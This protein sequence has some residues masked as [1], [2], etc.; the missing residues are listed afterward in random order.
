M[1]VD[2]YGNAMAITKTD[3]MILKVYATIY[4]SFTI[5][6][7]YY[8]NAGIAFPYVFGNILGTTN[9][10]LGVAA[11]QLGPINYANY[12]LLDQSATIANI[13][14]GRKISFDVAGA[15]M[16]NK[17]VRHIGYGRQYVWNNSSYAPG[18]VMDLTAVPGLCTT[19][20][21]QTIG[22][23]DGIKTYFPLDY[24][25]PVK[26]NATFK[27]FVDN[28]EV[29]A[30]PIVA[31]SYDAYY[32][33]GATASTMASVGNYYYRTTV[34]YPA[35]TSGSAVS[36]VLYKQD[37]PMNPITTEIIAK[38]TN[39]TVESFADDNSLY[40]FP[41]AS[42]NHCL[43]YRYKYNSSSSG[44][45]LCSIDSNTKEITVVQK[46]T[47]N[48]DII[49][50]ADN[51]FVCLAGTLFF[52]NEQGVVTNLGVGNRVDGD[53]VLNTGTKQ[54][55]KIAVTDGVPSKTLLGTYT[56]PTSSIVGQF[57]KLPE[58]DL[59]AVIAVE[60]LT[61]NVLGPTA[62]VTVINRA[63]GV[64]TT[65]TYKN[66]I[67]NLYA[68]NANASTEI[69]A[70]GYKYASQGYDYHVD[71]VNKHVYPYAV[72][73]GDS[74]AW[75]N[76]NRIGTGGFV[77][78]GGRGVQIKQSPEF[79]TGFTLSEAPAAG[80]AVA[81]TGELFGFL[82]TSDYKLSYSAEFIVNA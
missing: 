72:V 2:E 46:L 48:G 68:Q 53:I 23:G 24:P 3:T 45:Y 29:T 54:I 25:Y 28:V 66:G 50:A 47:T 16:N 30:T 18:L 20:Q 60:A 17:F 76:I 65:E 73:R 31:K 12:D 5:N 55:F 33:A 38:A 63:T 8:L 11:I 62:H 13:T 52:I 71:L 44:V 37:D 69:Y 81:V 1:I 58:T 26:N 41:T 49:F 61:S 82:K 78:T 75:M 34:S 51:R 74:T 15:A 10:Y 9:S 56:V 59:Y 64:V 40:I 39:Y 70:I 4:L 35:G 42:P 36:L 14:N 67:S 43:L 19:I 77:Q 22:A 57:K 6:N 80:A 21:K 7:V 32:A 79:I 27:V